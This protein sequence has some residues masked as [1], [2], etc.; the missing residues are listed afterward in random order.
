M[1][2]NTGGRTS[3]NDN[4]DSII[5]KLNK[6]KKISS[7]GG[8]YWMGRDIQKILGY[9]SWENFQNVIHKACMACESAGEAS[10]NH[11]HAITKLVMAGSGT[12]VQRTDW[13][14][15]RYACYLIAMN[16]DSSK[17]E[18]GIAQTYFAVQTRKQEIQDQLTDA[19]RRLQLRERVR[20]ANKSL[21][22]TAKRVGVQRYALFQNAGYIGLYDMGLSDIKYKKGIPKNDDL[23]DRAGRTELAANEFRITQAEDKLIRDRINNERDAIQTHL[24]VGREVRATINKLGGTMPENLPTEEPIKKLATKLKKNLKIDN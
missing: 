10:H 20:N 19:E 1:I 16:G 4:L 9:S 21:T 3:M 8:E 17:S 7:R 6:A 22:S 13:Y 23:L 5:N 11:F 12:M 18:I 24:D 2:F 14:L 15:T